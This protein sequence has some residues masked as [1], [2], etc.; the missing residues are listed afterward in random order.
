MNVPG[1]PSSQLTANSRG[2]GSARTSD[3]FRPVGKPAPPRPRKPASLTDLDKIVARAFPGDASLEQFVAA[4]FCVCLKGSRRRISVRM[5]RLGRGRGNFRAVGLHDLHMAD[6]ADRR[7]VAGAHAW[8][9][10]HPDVGP[11]FFRQFS[12]EPFRADQRAGQRIAH[13][14]RDRRRRPLAVL[15]DVE[16]GVESGDLIDLGQRQP[17]LLCQGGEMR[18]RQI[19]VTI[20]DQMQMFDQEVAPAFAVAEQ[21]ADLIEGMRIDLPAFRRARRLA[22]PGSPAGVGRP[23]LLRQCRRR[24][25]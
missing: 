5:R 19:A 9:P 1:S 18:G 8:R 16:M 25:G 23:I 4:A 21:R 6:G 13:P 3:H 12:Q 7:T 22:L 2:A 11:E 17:H 24:L 20:L 15:H 14:H 10:H